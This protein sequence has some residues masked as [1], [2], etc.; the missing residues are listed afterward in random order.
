MVYLFNL[1]EKIMLNAGV[2]YVMYD[3]YEKY[4]S[5]PFNASSEIYSKNTTIFAIGLDISLGK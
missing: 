1:G 2:V 4:Y 3:D 5:A